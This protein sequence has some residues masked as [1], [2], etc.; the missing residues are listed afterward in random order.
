M[1]APTDSMKAKQGK[2]VPLPVTYSCFWLVV[3]LARFATSWSLNCLSEV[4]L[5]YKTVIKHFVVGGGGA[6]SQY[7]EAV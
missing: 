6:R 5:S 7:S 2:L 1:T 4:G 3:F